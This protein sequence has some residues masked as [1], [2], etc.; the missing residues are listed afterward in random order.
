MQEMGQKNQLGQ[1]STELWDYYA[2]HRRDFPWRQTR[3]PYGILLSEIMLQ[4]TQVERVVGYYEKFLARWPTVQ[5]LAAA[6]TTELLQAWQGLGYNRRALYLRQ[7]AQAIVA[8]HDSIVPP[9]LAELTALPGVGPNTAGAVLAYAF[10]QP[11]IF[12]ETNIRKTFIHFFFTDQEKVSDDLIR[13]L[14]EQTIDR[15]NPR[16]WYWAVVDYGHHLGRKRIVRNERSQHYSKQSKFEG[17]NRQL[18]AA[19]L[20][21]L[22]GQPQSLAQLVQQ[23][24]AD[25]KL[26]NKNIE[27]LVGEGFLQ[28]IGRKLVI[29][30]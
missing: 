7:A 12:I 5:D 16:E 13:N 23:T 21:Q 1:F 4:Q 18:R 24:G 6:D 22:L 8:N 15:Q 29:K 17:S 14:I 10:N 19:L 11:V 3:D 30:P 26:V 9:A 20:K 28:K 25:P 2:K 27:S